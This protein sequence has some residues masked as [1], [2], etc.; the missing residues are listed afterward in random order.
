MLPGALAG[1]TREAQHGRDSE[2]ICSYLAHEQNALRLKSFGAWMP[3]GMRSLFPGESGLVPRTPERLSSVG[4]QRELNGQP[5]GMGAAGNS[6]AT[7]TPMAEQP[8]SP[9]TESC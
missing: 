9:P 3:P 6:G 5:A 1:S 7:P 2:I 8:P 4:G